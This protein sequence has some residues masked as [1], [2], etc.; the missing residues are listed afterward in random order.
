MRF[1]LLLAVFALIEPRFE[2]P[3]REDLVLIDGRY[4]H[5]KVLSDSDAGIQ[6]LLLDTGGTVFLPWGLIDEPYRTKIMKDRGKLQE[7]AKVFLEDGE[8][9]TTKM[10]EPYEGRVVNDTAEEITLKHRGS[11]LKLP[12]A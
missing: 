6:V 3:K 11:L 12:K 5:V 7:E 9:I 4:L 8:R 2:A 10:G 1:V